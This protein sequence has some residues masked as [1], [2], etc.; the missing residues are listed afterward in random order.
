MANSVAVDRVFYALADPTRRH[1][2]EELGSNGPR[3]ASALSAQADISRQAIAKHL[4]IM[5]EAG[6]VE[7]SRAGREVV[8]AVDAHQ[9]AATGRWMQRIAQ[10]WDN[11]HS[12]RDARARVLTTESE[13]ATTSVSA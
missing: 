7:R 13:A 5:E 1:I 3:S 10:R 4:T 12:V 2:L 9:F 8:F 11:A 6:L